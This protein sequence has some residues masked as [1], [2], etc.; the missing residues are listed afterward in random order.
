[1]ANPDNSLPT[2]T[3]R[4]HAFKGG[5]KFLLTIVK[6]E[7]RNLSQVVQNQY[8]PQQNLPDKDGLFSK[9]DA[10]FRIKVEGCRLA[11]L[12]KLL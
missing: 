11:T 9:S 7:V 8:F 2:L 10:Y 3:Y 6:F 1:M 4:A 12:L 5:K